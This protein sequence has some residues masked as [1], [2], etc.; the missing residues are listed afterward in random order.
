[1]RQMPDRA[2][3][4]S[5]ASIEYLRSRPWRG[6]VRELQ[7]AIEHVA[8]LVEPEQVIEPGDIPIYDDAEAAVERSP[9]PQLAGP[10][11]D[12]KDQ[13]IA[14]TEG[15]AGLADAVS[16]VDDVLHGNT[17]ADVAPASPLTRRIV[18][19]LRRRLIQQSTTIESLQLLRAVEA[20]S[21]SLEPGW[22]E[23]FQDRM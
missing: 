10:F 18:T 9:A 5:D 4:L 17:K 3:R 13:A 20:V 15:A 14:Q 6:N 16:R 11:H 8:V 2:P 1:H 7:N 23:H 12:V 22:S 21:A 19:L